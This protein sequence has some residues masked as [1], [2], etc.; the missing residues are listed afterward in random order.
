M[1][2]IVALTGASGFIGQHITNA[3]LE[4]G[5][6]VR[7]LTRGRCDARQ[8]VEWVRGSLDSEQSLATL[9]RGA[10]AVIHCAGQVRGGSPAVFQRVN[11]DGT[12][13]MVAAAKAAGSCE[14]FL[15]ISSL[16][17]RHPDLSWYARSK[18]EAERLAIDAA[19]TL[20][21]SVFRPTAVYG[22]GDRELH[23]VFA[24]LL[25]GW[26]PRLGQ[27]DAR[28]SFLHVQDLA[29][30]CTDWLAAARVRTTVY[31]LSDGAMGGYDWDKLTAIGAAVRGAPVRQVNVPA[32]LLR[33][34][35]TLN[36]IWH[37][38]VGGEPMLTPSKVNELLHP[39]WS[40]SDRAISADLGWR[41]G[42]ELERALRGRLF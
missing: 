27:A 19:G 12:L 16:A 39:D 7:A 33:H 42:I 17:A 15:L 26:L 29:R 22:P 40:S 9:V 25:R 14:R 38:L 3:L 37:R 8:G 2:Q 36:L 5:I 11:V 24:W 31:E 30:A 20:P 13:R 6:G 28:L 32:S 41:P 4:R 10:S 18:F 23:P 35:A 34:L 1:T 21:V